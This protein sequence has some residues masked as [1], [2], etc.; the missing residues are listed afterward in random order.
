MDIERT[1]NKRPLGNLSTHQLALHLAIIENKHPVATAN[2][3]IIVG[4]IKEDGGT[5][6]ASLRRRT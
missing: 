5:W 6:P 1:S 3:F 2:Q 4:G